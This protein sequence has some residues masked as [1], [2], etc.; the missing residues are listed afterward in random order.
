M[1][2]TLFYAV[3]G[4]AILVMTVALVV[5]WRLRRLTRGGS[6][7]RV[8]NLLGAFVVLFLAG[9][10]AAPILQTLKGDVAL[11]LMAVVFL[12]GA[13]FVVLVLRIIHGLVEQVVKDLRL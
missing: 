2:M 3:I 8:V 7:G 1:T 13:I 11:L 9:Y 12:F 10:L 4:A 6:I 5:V